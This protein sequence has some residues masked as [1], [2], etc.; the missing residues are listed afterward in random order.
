MKIVRI[1]QDRVAV[2]IGKKGE[3]K[4]Q[5]EER[6]G[7]VLD[8]DSESG[9]VTIDASKSGDPLQEL[10]AVDV[11]RAVGRGFSPD[12]AYSL[13]S[14]DMYLDVI[15]MREYTGKSPKH[16]RRIKARII[17]KAGRTRRTIEQLTGARLSIY[18]GT[19]AIISEIGSLEVTRTAVDMI[20]SGSEHSMVYRFL[21]RKRREMKMARFDSLIMGKGTREEEG[22]Y[23][24]DDG[25]DHW[26]DED[27][28]EV[29]D[30][31][32]GGEGEEGEQDEQE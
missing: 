30:E 17:G 2:L 25:E 19:V 11:V 28:D 27:E 8:I 13:L 21:E 32:L 6:T 24:E 14:D 15:D 31:D 12:N 18:G 22:E 7:A 9:E 29:E 20:L 26:D 10:K 23:E 16:M 3:V 5:M 4:R 1:P